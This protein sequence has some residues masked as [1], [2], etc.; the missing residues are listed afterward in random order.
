[1]SRKLFAIL[2]LDEERANVLKPSMTP[3]EYIETE[4][5]WLNES[6]INLRNCLIADEDDEII[7]SQ[8][9]NYLLEWA[10]KYSEER[11]EGLSPES[12]EQWR[13]HNLFDPEQFVYIVVLS[14]GGEPETPNSEVIGVSRSFAIARQMFLKQ[15]E[16]E[17][18]TTKH[19]GWEIYCD[20]DMCY[21]AGQRGY[22]NEHHSTLYIVKR[23][24]ET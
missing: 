21:D 19:K 12:Y 22:Y 2:E 6:G 11:F 17:V 4:F 15:K 5:G 23:K 14:W 9:I 7:W 8:Y 20:S 3:V 18:E 1:M 13:E 16:E 24:L 10:L